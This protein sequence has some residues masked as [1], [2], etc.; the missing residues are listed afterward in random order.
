MTLIPLTAKQS[1]TDVSQKYLERRS[2][3]SSVLLGFHFSCEV[4]DKGCTAGQ[5]S[6]ANWAFL[7]RITVSI[8]QMKRVRAIERLLPRP[9]TLTHTSLS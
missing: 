2:S 6:L 3:L 9:S 7:L 1:H 4:E 5:G 8:L